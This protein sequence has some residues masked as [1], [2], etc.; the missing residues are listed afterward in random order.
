MQLKLVT[1]LL[2][3]VDDLVG[4]LDLVGREYLVAIRVEQRGN[5]A[6]IL[7]EPTDQDLL[8]HAN[9]CLGRMLEAICVEVKL[10]FISGRLCSI[11]LTFGK[12]KLC[13]DEL[14]EL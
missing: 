2:T 10:A 12:L 9:L 14:L 6:Q 11:L 13:L 8:Q 5:T 3:L 1:R 7:A 4:L